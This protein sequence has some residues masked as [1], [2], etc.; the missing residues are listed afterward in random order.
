MG[1]K[2][3]PEVSSQLLT[4]LSRSAPGTASTAAVLRI[5]SVNATELVAD[6]DNYAALQTAVATL[7]GSLPGASGSGYVFVQNVQPGE[8]EP[9]NVPPTG[10]T[11]AVFPPN[12]HLN[13]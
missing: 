6:V 5:V 4:P 12:F 9:R 7:G 13:S 2:A 10:F 3:K 1:R 8:D 11:P